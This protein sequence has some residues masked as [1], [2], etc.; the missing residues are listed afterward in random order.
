MKP[1]K[2]LIALVIIIAVLIGCGWFVISD[3]LN[4]K[5][6]KQVA[7]SVEEA[8]KTMIDKNDEK[9]FSG[10]VMIVKEGKVV[11]K[12]VS[13]YANLNRKESINEDT[14]FNLASVSKQFTAMAIMILNEEGKLELDDEITKYIHDPYFKN[15]TI[16]HLLTHTSGLGEYYNLFYKKWDNSKTMTNNDV[17]DLLVKYQPSYDFEP[18]KQFRYSNTGYA[19]LASIIEKVSGKTYGAFLQEKIFGPLEMKNTLAYDLIN[20]PK[21]SNRAYGYSYDNGLYTP[22]D[23]VFFD[24]IVGDGNIYST[25]NDLVKWDK[26]L[27]DGKLISRSNLE[28]MF[29]PNIPADGKKSVYGFGWMIKTDSGDRTVFHSGSWVGFRSMII[30]NLSNKYTLIFLS[31]T[32]E[33]CYKEMFDKISEILT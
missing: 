17:I 14:A 1:G 8:V 11:Y 19:L 12:Y 5:Q 20:D 16:R 30:R 32:P 18:G 33:D 3:A 15:I 4:V 28:K 6:E 23:L 29:T 26:A 24:G 27:H 13:G 22:N 9:S 21:I 31:N 10:V 25:A 2:V 7:Q